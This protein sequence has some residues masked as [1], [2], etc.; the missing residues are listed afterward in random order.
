M[1]EEEAVKFPLFFCSDAKTGE[2]G[3]LRDAFRQ[4]AAKVRKPT[5]SL[6]AR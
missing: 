4:V 5:D 3:A 6:A 1:Q 2:S